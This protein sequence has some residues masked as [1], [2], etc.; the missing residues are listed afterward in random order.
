MQGLGH[1][2]VD[3]HHGVVASLLDVE[4]EVAAGHDMD[5]LLDA[6]VAHAVRLLLAHVPLDEG[7]GG[8]PLCP[9]LVG[10]VVA[11]LGGGS[12]CS[13]V[14]I[15]RGRSGGGGRVA[16]RG[17]ACSRALLGT[18]VSAD[19]D[20]ALEVDLHAVRELERLEVGVA[21]HAGAGTE[22]LDLVELGHELG[23]GDAA[24]LVHQL[25]GRPLAV[26]SHAVSDQHVELLLIVLDGEHHGHGLADLDEAGHL[27]S[28]GTLADLDLHPAANIVSSEVS[29]D[30]IQHVN[31]EGPVKTSN[32]ISHGL[33]L[34]I[35]CL[36]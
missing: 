32:I 26:M 27:A 29:T 7:V 14:I 24:L 16:S 28:P 13:V 11:G 17:A 6:H 21:E 30:N 3:I 20:C 22:V 10:T 8:E 31:R 1:R 2:G 34:S 9:G 23:P 5:H 19:L 25:D 33:M 12:R 15:L 18:R 4:G 36:T 35:S